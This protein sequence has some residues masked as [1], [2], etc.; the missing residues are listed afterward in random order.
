MLRSAIRCMRLLPELCR[1]SC[2]EFEP[3]HLSTEDHLPEF[4]PEP[5]GFLRIISSSKAFGELKKCLLL[6]LSCFE[7]LFNKFN[8]HTVSTEPSIFRHAPDLSGYL[9]R[10]GDALANSLFF[11]CH[12]T[13]M[14]Q[15]GANIGKNKLQKVVLSEPVSSLF[16]SAARIFGGR[17]AGNA[18]VAT[19]RLAYI[20]AKRG[21]EGAR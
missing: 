1:E 2:P 15:S 18:S 14:H 20:T 11:G 17:L 16:N 3:G 19:R 12:Y 7:P 8:Q 5:F 21:A 10:E 9:C 6:L 13:I 4:L